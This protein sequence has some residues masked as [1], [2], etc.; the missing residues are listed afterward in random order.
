MNAKNNLL[1]L[2]A[3]MATVAAVSLIQSLFR[4]NYAAVSLLA[5][6]AAC[7][8]L[9]LTKGKTWS[10][11]AGITLICLGGVMS[12]SG[13]IPEE[14]LSRLANALFFLVP[15]VIFF[16]LFL[17]GR[18][19]KHY[20]YGS[21]LLMFG[22]FF[23]LMGSHSL[24]RMSGALFVAAMGCAALSGRR[25]KR[26]Q[27]IGKGGFMGGEYGEV[28]SR[29][30][31]SHVL[32][33]LERTEACAKCGMCHA[34][35]RAEEMILRA[36]NMDAL[37]KEFV[38]VEIEPGRFLAAAA[39]LYL[40]PLLFLLAGFIGGFAAA[41]ALGFRG[42]GSFA[43]FILGVALAALALLFLRKKEREQRFD[44]YTP[45]ASRI[46]D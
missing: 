18:R 46:S 6:G 42:A 26:L 32:V 35:A 14:P 21:H 23:M 1:L 7:A 2:C 31:D 33:K 37:P 44:A 5:G 16:Y 8:L 10:L 43:A 4:I 27:N 9:Y 41:E 29:L 40:V 22:V 17:R 38:S 45:V 12:L 36:R 25:L 20:V 34:G 19:R 13:K 11:F 15:A 39:L 28:V 24:R 3:I 30:D